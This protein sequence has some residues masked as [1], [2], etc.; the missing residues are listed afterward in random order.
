MPPGKVIA[1]AVRKFS[2]PHLALT[3]GEACAARGPEG[4]PPM[5]KTAIEA[6]VGLA[7]QSMND[8]TAS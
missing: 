1:K 5:L 8:P 4:V 3:V 2:K 6:A 7:R